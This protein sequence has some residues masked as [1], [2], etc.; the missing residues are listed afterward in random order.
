MLQAE[1]PEVSFTADIAE[2]MLRVPLERYA[3]LFDAAKP[4]NSSDIT[5]LRPLPDRQLPQFHKNRYTRFFH[6]KLPI[7]YSRYS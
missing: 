3:A 4:A 6:L 5:L 1:F 7:D 2:P